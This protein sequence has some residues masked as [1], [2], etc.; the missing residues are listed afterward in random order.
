MAD[1][2]LLPKDL[3]GLINGRSETCFEIVHFLSVCSSWRSAVPTPSYGRSIGF[4][5]LL[6]VF[7]HDP[8][9]EDDDAHCKFRKIQ[10]FLLR[11]QTPFGA[12]SLLVG[13]SQRKSGKL[14]LLSPLEHS[15]R[16]K[17]GITLSTLSSQIISLGDY[18]K[19]KF[20]A[21]TTRRYRTRREKY[22]KRVAFLQLDSEDGKDFVVV[23]G[24]LGN[25]MTYRSGDKTWT[26]IECPFIGYRDM[27][28]FKGK[29][30]VI[31]MRGRGRVYVI[32]PSLEISEIQAVTQ[33]HET[34][35]ERLVISGEELLLV[36]RITPGAYCH[37]HKHAWFRLF[38]LEEEGQRKWV[39]VIDLEDR[40]VFLGV[41]WNL[42]Y[43]ARELPGMKGNCVVFVDPKYP[44]EHLV[45]DLRTRKTS[46]AFNEC[47]G[48]MGAFGQN[49]E[50]LLSCGIVTHLIQRRASVPHKL[51]LD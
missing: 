46:M 39:R 36:Q 48:Y 44:Y 40:V 22:S 12:D 5:S 1:W 31:D 30:Y 20:Y 38:R 18:Y 14:K 9:F 26:K 24:V 13:M 32:E 21:I 25:L 2:S 23:A 10:V 6:P 11:F 35:D 16:Y 8:R 43:S 45:F 3:L 41:D 7:N 34:F 50:S 4:N 37:E 29:F 15:S 33:S 47:R 49:Q 42:C 28:S 19:I 17:Y 27:V 51:N